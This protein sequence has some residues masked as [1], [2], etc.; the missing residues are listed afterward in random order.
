MEVAFFVVMAALIVVV[1]VAILTTVAGRLVIPF[2]VKA[3]LNDGEQRKASDYLNMLHADKKNTPTMGGVFMVPVVLISSSAILLLIPILLATD[4][5][6]Q[7]AWP[8]FGLMAFVVV[9]HAALGLVDDYCKLK[10]LGKDGLP[11]KAKLA[12]QTT[13]AA[14]ACFGAAV[15][16]GEDSRV[17]VLPYMTLDIGWL[18][19]PIGTF[20]MVGSSNA[21]NLTDGLDGLAG[22]TGLLAFMGMAVVLLIM[23]FT[24]VNMH[25]FGMEGIIFSL[26]AAGGLLG[27]L[28]WNRYPAKVFMGDTGSLSLG[29]MIGFIAVLTR[30]EIVLAVAGAV[31]VAEAGSVM[32]QV[33]YYKATKGRR[34][35]RCAPL[36]HHF[37]FGGMHEKAVTKRFWIAGFVFALMSVAMIPVL[38]DSNNSDTPQQTAEELERPTKNIIL[39]K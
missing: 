16:V 32:L 30:L 38:S 1:S 28:H 5:N 34:I 19:V 29:A 33:G 27:F 12:V 18:M 13:V 8:V 14:L 23:M 22:G 24:G 3:K 36:H 11:G 21:Y 37:Q 17:L 20:V 6:V 4:M 9:S 25:G 15:L 26:C 31:F 7:K 35:F 39:E 10:K 2:L